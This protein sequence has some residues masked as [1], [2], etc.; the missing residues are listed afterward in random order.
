[1]AD[2][3]ARELQKREQRAFEKKAN[4][5]ALNQEIALNFYPERADFTGERALGEEF[6]IDLFDSEPVR[7]RRDLGN[8]RAAMIR[9]RGRKWSEAVTEDDQLNQDPSVAP[10]LERLNDKF[11]TQLY[12]PTS[13][14]VRA[15]K[16]ADHDIVTFGNAISTAES[17][18]DQSGNRILM[19]RTW[20]PRDCAWYDDIN[21]VKQDVMFRRFKA[22]AR[23]IKKMFPD[24]ELHSTITKALE[25]EPDREFNLC[26]TMM[27]ADEYE[28]YNK[29][30]GRKTPFVSVYYDSDHKMLLRERPSQRFRYIVKRWQTISGSQ[31][32]Y[33]PAAMTGLPDGRG[34]QTMAMVLLQSGELALDP[35][36]K[37]TKGA[38]IGEVKVE[39]RGVTWVD[40]TY[41]ERLGPAIEPLLPQNRNLAIGI[42]LINRTTFS[43]RDIWHLTNLQLPQHGEKTAYESSLLYEEYIRANIPLFEPWEADEEQTLDEIFAVLLDMGEF[44]PVE[45]WPEVFSG[46]DLVWK[47]SNALQDAIEKAKA[48]QFTAALG[49]AAGVAKI[50]PKAIRRIDWGKGLTDAVRGNGSPAEWIR[51]EE[52]VAAEDQ[53]AA[54]VGD[55]VG[56][57]N[58]AGQ[59]ADVVKTGTEAAANIQGMMLPLGTKPNGAA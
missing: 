17:E 57:L 4:L 2:E 37:A 36:M 9:P 31:Y 30:R 51:K 52:D 59:A 15:E 26:H 50:D 39:A 25:K 56:G 55:I 6:A 13:G 33:S 58:A 41:D 11:R 21:G 34:I 43:L 7:C 54:Q 53:Q 14:F 44:G 42:D 5:D 38:V 19:C 28:Y 16:E 22:S 3:N 35:P 18:I 48:A 46:R 27:E 47:F 10:F 29:P 23:H 1:V 20:H 40:K 45:A 49:L 12:R 8:A 32:G 24:A